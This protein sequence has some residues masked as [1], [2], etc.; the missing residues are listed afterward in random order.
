MTSTQHFKQT[1][2]HSTKSFLRTHSH[3]PLSGLQ[4]SAPRRGGA[5]VSLPPTAVA[6][7][8]EAGMLCRCFVGLVFVWVFQLAIGV[9]LGGVRTFLL[10][11]TLPLTPTH[12]NKNTHTNTTHTHTHTHTNHHHKLSPVQAGHNA[13]HRNAPRA[14]ITDGLLAARYGKFEYLPCV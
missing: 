2:G 5:A 6:A 1:Y 10:M 12:T 11:W 3:A 9:G 8:H 13:T 4:L 14:L 7:T